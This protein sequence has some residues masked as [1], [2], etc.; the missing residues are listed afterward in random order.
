MSAVDL[1]ALQ[2]RLRAFAAER[3]WQPFHTPKNLSMAL[4]VEAPERDDNLQ[5]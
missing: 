5:W 2:A 3:H 4:I 1:D